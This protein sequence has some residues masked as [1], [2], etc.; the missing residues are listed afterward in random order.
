MNPK[1]AKINAEIGKTRDK[2][3][4][5]KPGSGEL[6]RQKPRSRIPRSWSWY[7]A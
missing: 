4:S 1:L 6:E 7:G 3:A 5:I 2:I